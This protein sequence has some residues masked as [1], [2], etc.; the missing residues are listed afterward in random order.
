M[1]IFS[2][3][4]ILADLLRLETLQK[5]HR[6]LEESSYQVLGARATLIRLTDIDNEIKQ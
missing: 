2:R 4:V 6:I 5:F 1:G 3:Y